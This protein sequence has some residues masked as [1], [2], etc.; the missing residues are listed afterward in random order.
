MGL[1]RLSLP[2]G[3]ELQERFIVFTVKAIEICS[4]LPKTQVGKHIGGQ[5]LRSGSSPAANYAEARNAESNNDFVHKLKIVL[6][7]LNESIVWLEVIDRCRLLSNDRIG[8]V[9]DECNQL[10]KIISA[11]IVT[12][13]QK[14]G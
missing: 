2:K 8:P 5:L 9:L 6:K 14:D 10:A 11:S 13:K 4:S 12:A 7:E 3:H 1:R